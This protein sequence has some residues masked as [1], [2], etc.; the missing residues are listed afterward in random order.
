MNA[1]PPGMLKRDS[2]FV[3]VSHEFAF[4]FRYGFM[5]PSGL[6]LTSLPEQK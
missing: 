3:P 4:L 1:D 6:L 5:G 2:K